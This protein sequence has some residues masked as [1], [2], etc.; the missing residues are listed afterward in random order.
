MSIPISAQGFFFAKMR[1]K[2]RKRERRQNVQIWERQIRDG[3]LSYLGIFSSSNK[4]LVFFFFSSSFSSRV[5]FYTIDKFHNFFKKFKSDMEAIWL[6]MQQTSR[7][8]WV[9]K[10]DSAQS[11]QFSYYFAY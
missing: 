10:I 7:A 3:E 2:E 1:E 11:A 8:I 9:D 4:E 5:V 6:L